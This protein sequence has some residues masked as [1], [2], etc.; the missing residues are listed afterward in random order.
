MTKL[1]KRAKNALRKATDTLFKHIILPL[2]V[3]AGEEE[4]AYFFL[5]IGNRHSID[6]AWSNTED[7][8]CDGAIAIANIPEAA[9]AFLD[10]STGVDLLVRE[11]VEN[12]EEGFGEEF[13]VGHAPSKE[14]NGWH[15][16]DALPDENVIPGNNQVKTR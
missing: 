9:S 4:D 8:S 2:M 16:I 12:N 5:V 6:I 10:L 11:N 3:W 14:D 13:Q 7:L 15:S 1:S